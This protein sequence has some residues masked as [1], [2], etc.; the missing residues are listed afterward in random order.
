LRLDIDL[1][2]KVKVGGARPASRHSFVRQ[3]KDAKVPS[4]AAACGR[5]L[6]P[7]SIDGGEE[8]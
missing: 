6:P 7:N 5:V 8:T 4:L 2:E 3:Q 1:N